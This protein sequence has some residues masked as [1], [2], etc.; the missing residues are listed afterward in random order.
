M[1]TES[2]PKE[3][4]FTLQEIASFRVICPYYG[5]GRNSVRSAAQLS[6]PL[7]PPEIIIVVFAGKHS[8]KVFSV[9]WISLESITAIIIKPLFVLL[10][11]HSFCYYS[12]N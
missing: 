11:G 12:I 1:T 6:T 5:M 10:I 8:F 4:F 9:I 7:V 3:G 2:H